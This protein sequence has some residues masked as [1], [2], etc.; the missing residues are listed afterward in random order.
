[1]CIQILSTTG[2]ADI[3]TTT[4]T[5][6]KTLI[7]RCIL[8]YRHTFIQEQQT[9]YNMS[10][11]THLLHSYTHN[12]INLYP[13]CTHVFLSVLRHK[14]HTHTYTNAHTL[15][16]TLAHGCLPV[17]LSDKMKILWQNKQ[18]FIEAKEKS[19]LSQRQQ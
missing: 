9:H 12:V 13:C 3:T 7:K 8:K 18:K 10:V 11:H 17:V 1:M 19:E 6:C 15:T 4:T 5:P 2:T 14:T 16:M